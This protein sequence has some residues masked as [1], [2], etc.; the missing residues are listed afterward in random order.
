[1]PTRLALAAR[2]I[3]TLHAASRKNPGS[4]RPVRSIG[5]A[6]G[7]VD[8]AQLEQAVRDAEAAGLIERQVNGHHVLLTA[9]GRRVAGSTPS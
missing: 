3:A 6:T 4:W 5:K 1:M 9:E 2:F 8:S 7:I